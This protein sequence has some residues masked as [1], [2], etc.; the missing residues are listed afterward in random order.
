MGIWAVSV[1]SSREAAAA[2]RLLA[3]YVS[4]MAGTAAESLCTNFRQITV[5]V[6]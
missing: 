3:S 1:G 4:G 6:L 2:D 5:T